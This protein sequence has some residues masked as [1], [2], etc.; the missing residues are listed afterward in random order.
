MLGVGA[1]API[2][3]RHPSLEER[4]LACGVVPSSIQPPRPLAFSLY[5]GL[6]ITTVI[7]SFALDLVG[8]LAGLGD[9]AVP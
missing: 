3:G 9:L 1:D 7:G 4:V 8:L 2:G 6:P 5:G